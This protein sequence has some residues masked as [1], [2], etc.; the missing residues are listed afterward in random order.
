MWLF[1][2][3]ATSC[4]LRFG[5]D[6]FLE[7]SLMA[8]DLRLI[9]SPKWN[10]WPVAT[11]CFLHLFPVKYSWCFALWIILEFTITW[12]WDQSATDSILGQCEALN[13]VSQTQITNFTLKN[14]V[15][16]HTW[17]SLLVG[18]IWKDWLYEAIRFRY[19]AG[20]VP[21]SAL[22]QVALAGLLRG[23]WME[24]TSSTWPKHGSVE[25]LLWKPLHL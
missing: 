14:N 13:N 19:S 21:P 17:K 2:L 15:S 20:W 18:K 4:H 16:K 23:D 24:I 25:D 22:C 3:K 5:L 9:W 1:N 11:K 8:T 7:D 6:A 10:P 12:I